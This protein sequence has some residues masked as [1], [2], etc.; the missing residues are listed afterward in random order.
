MEP[1][2]PIK[3]AVLLFMEAVLSCFWRQCCHVFGGTAAVYGGTAVVHRGGVLLKGSAVVHGGSAVIYGGSAAVYEGT[4]GG[5][6]TRKETQTYK[7]L[8]FQGLTSQTTQTY[9]TLTYES[10]RYISGPDCG[11]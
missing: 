10:L 3:E 1:L 6:L 8:R 4:D 9:K 2:L 11:G 5:M 7:T